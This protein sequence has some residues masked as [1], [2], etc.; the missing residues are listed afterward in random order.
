[1]EIVVKR[2]EI[3]SH[4]WK[5]P[6]LTFCPAEAEVKALAVF[7]HG[8]TSHFADLLNWASRLSEISVATTIFGLPGHKLGSD[9]EVQSLDD[10]E[11]YVPKTYCKA[12]ESLREELPKIEPGTKLFVGGHSLG[13]LLGLMSLEEEDFQDYELRGLAVGLGLLKENQRSLLSSPLFKQNM[14][15][16]NQLVSKALQSESMLPWL[17]KVKNNIKTQNRDIHLITGK[18]DIIMS[19]DSMLN[20]K[21]KLEEKGNRTSYEIPDN[22]PHHQ[23]ELASATIKKYV[24]SVLSN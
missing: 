15:I 21:R 17:S 22:L 3:S 12:T 10:F 19:S 2:K 14:S 24:K 6:C 1:M 4:N 8:F 7:S 5:L 20:M 23:P 16:R 11:Q 13:A 18:N 9:S